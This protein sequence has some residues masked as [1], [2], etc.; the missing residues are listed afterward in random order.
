MYCLKDLSKWNLDF[1]A[2]IVCDDCTRRLVAGYK[3]RNGEW[4]NVRKKYPRHVRRK[5][6]QT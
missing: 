5:G 2:D 6:A 3:M 1:S 4:W